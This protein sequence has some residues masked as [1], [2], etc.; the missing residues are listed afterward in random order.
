MI[1]PSLLHQFVSLL[2]GVS[3]AL[4]SLMTNVERP[5]PMHSLGDHDATMMMV[6]VEGEH[7][8]HTAPEVPRSA[9][10]HQCRCGMICCG[11]PAVAILAMAPDL[12]SNVLRMPI[13]TPLPLPMTWAAAREHV[14]PFAIGPPLVMRG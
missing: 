8:A 11:A 14:L 10:D 5:C 12:V 7:G 4:L 1:R 6:G 2:C 13:A 3:F 9:P